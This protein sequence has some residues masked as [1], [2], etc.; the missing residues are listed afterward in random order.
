MIRIHGGHGA[1]AILRLIGD[2]E[3]T[4]RWLRRSQRRCASR[5]GPELLLQ[6][7]L[8]TAVSGFDAISRGG[9]WVSTPQL[10]S[11]PRSWRRLSSHARVLSDP[12]DWARAS[13]RSGLRRAAIEASMLGAAHACANPVSARF[14]TITGSRCP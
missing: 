10:H 4:R 3:A 7:R 11:G 8:T 14:G 13:M 6:P 1:G 9:A 2:E 12:G 5:S